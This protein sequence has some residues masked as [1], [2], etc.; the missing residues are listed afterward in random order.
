MTDGGIS[1]GS[2]SK[3]IDVGSIAHGKESRTDDDGAGSMRGTSA[4]GVAWTDEH[5][6]HRRIAPT[7]VFS[8]APPHKKPPT[9]SSLLREPHSDFRAYNFLPYEEYRG[10]KRDQIIA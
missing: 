6:P 4:E 9:F 7:T 8:T 3:D 5:R 2:A 10:L 1:I